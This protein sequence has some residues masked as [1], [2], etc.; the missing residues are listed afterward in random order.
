MRIRPVHAGL[1]DIRRLKG[2]HGHYSVERGA[3]NEL[4]ENA[5]LSPEATSGHRLGGVFQF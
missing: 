1:V 3:V 5:A 2:P 4:R